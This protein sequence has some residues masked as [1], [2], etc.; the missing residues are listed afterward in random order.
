MV[1]L[2]SDEPDGLTPGL[3]PLVGPQWCRAFAS[4]RLLGAGNST[5]LLLQ[6]PITGEI[7]PTMQANPSNI[8]VLKVIGTEFN[9]RLP[10]LRSNIATGGTQNG[11]VPRN[12]RNTGPMSA[13]GR[14]K[15]PLTVRTLQAPFSTFADPEI[16]ELSSRFGC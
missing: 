15:V 9:K 5:L 7:G 14:R 8:D 12:I 16:C 10:W 6:L 2:P 4:Q 11:D 13:T 1:L 3:L